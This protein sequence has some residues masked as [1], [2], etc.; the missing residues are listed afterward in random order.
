M[1][2]TFTLK[3]E[4]REVAGRQSNKNLRATNRI[5]AVLYGH[6]LE[7]QSLSLD[8]VQFEKVFQNAGESTLIELEVEGQGMV[9]VLIHAVDRNALSHAITH[10]DLYQVRMD[11]KITTEVEFV[12]EGVAPAE[13]QLGGVLVR[14]MTHVEVEC[15]PKDLPH[16]L[17]V[18]ITTL[19][20]FDDTIRVENLTVP[21]GVTIMHAMDD[22]I[23]LV[24]AP[25]SEEELKAL[26]EEVVV[27]VDS[28]EVEGAKK[29]DEKSAEGADESKK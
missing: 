2:E 15:L 20:T 16:H 13:K 18:D 8:A 1:S 7:T 24:E 9:N 27:N 23:A 19:A 28:V 29:E 17:T 22:V 12:F 5:P 10:A 11:E 3:A 26:D 14:N 4:K 25:R 6:G 21:A